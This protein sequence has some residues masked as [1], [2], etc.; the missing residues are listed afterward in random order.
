M[1]SSARRLRLF[2]AL[3]LPAE[4]RRSIV[5]WG[6]HE[7]ADPALRPVDEE[8][9]HVTLAFL[10]HRPESEVEP[11]ARL[12]SALRHPAPRLALSGVTA[13]GG[14]RPRLFAL[15]AE[16]P[17]AAAL[18]AELVGVGREAGLI[19]PEERPFWP[20]VTVA[21]VRSGRGGSRSPERLVRPPG[22]LPEDLRKP[23]RAVRVTLYRSLT[24]P[25]GAEY[26]PLAQVEL[27]EPATVR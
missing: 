24:S 8:A 18:H 1:S 3:D 13:I 21:R 20:H 22:G 9:L 10:G 12:V 5:R 26:V 4:V 16:A 11:L 17:E 14:R 2:I 7:L 23:F 27:P 25:A 6:D 15:D 19:E